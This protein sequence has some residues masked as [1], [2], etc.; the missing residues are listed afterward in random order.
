MYKC[1]TVPNWA[2]INSSHRC[3]QLAIA[4]GLTLCWMMEIL[5]CRLGM[6]L[7]SSSSSVEEAVLF[8]LDVFT[9]PP[10]EPGEP[11]DET[12]A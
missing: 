9:L 4:N 7:M 5:I 8:F 10:L 6:L 12:W 1:Q 3:R 11:G 2:A